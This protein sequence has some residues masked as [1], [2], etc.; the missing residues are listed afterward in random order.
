MLRLLHFSVITEVSLVKVHE[1]TKLRVVE[2]AKSTITKKLI[3]ITVSKVKYLLTT[4]YSL[5]PNNS[6]YF[7]FND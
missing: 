5:D 7:I 3:N 4:F 1:N 6:N 2:L